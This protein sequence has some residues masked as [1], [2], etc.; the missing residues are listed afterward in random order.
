MKIQTNVIT[1]LMC[2]FRPIAFSSMKPF[3]LCIFLILISSTIKAE[4][5]L[6]TGSYTL[7]TNNEN[8][9]CFIHF[10]DKNNNYHIELTEDLA[11]DILF[12]TPLSFGEYTIEEERLLFVDEILGFKV[13]ALIKDRE[14][15]IIQG[16]PFMKNAVFSLWSEHSYFD[17]YPKPKR[18][19]PQ[20][21]TWSKANHNRKTDAL[22]PGIYKNSLY[23]TLILT[24]NNNYILLYSGI[25]LS[26]GSWSRDKNTIFLFDF[27]LNHS[28][29]VVLEGNVLTSC[30]LP[31]DFDGINLSLTPK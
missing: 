24:E 18:I 28:F 19:V 22:T 10:S 21:E 27:F 9:R 7:Q 25:L 16:F 17:D 26:Y 8:M 23:T 20:K 29:S 6:V 2:F 5:R 30:Y 14:F 3:F 31:G 1:L 11:S 15:E 4:E 13:V 12:Y